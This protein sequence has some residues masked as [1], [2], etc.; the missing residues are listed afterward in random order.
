MLGLAPQA[1]TDGA[2]PGL[3]RYR[4]AGRATQG[5]AWIEEGGEATQVRLGPPWPGES[6]HRR[7]RILS[8]N[9]N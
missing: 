6:W 1:R 3:D 8:T 2:R 7:Q 4:I 9:N 5:L